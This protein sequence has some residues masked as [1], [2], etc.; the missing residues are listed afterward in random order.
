MPTVVVNVSAD[1]ASFERVAALRSQER[2]A[3]RKVDA[4]K[5]EL[6]EAASGLKKVQGLLR[7]EI[8]EAREPNLFSGVPVQPAPSA[9]EGKG[10]KAKPLPQAGGDEAWKLKQIADL[11]GVRPKDHQDLRMA[12]IVTVGQ[13]EDYLAKH[14][15]VLKGEA[16][17]PE[18]AAKRVAD[19][20]MKFHADRTKAAVAEAAKDQPAAPE[21]PKR[22]RKKKADAAP[23]PAAE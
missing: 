2:A 16:S 10:R 8:D 15:G 4:L 20:V 5:A 21:K 9:G 17:L 14:D 23:A 7:R 11:D 13:Y 19:A 3:E 22:G 12:G 1:A 18:A 6:R